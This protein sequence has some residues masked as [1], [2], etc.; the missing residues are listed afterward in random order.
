MVT[1]KYSAIS[2][3]GQKVKGIVEAYNQVDAV[4]RIKNDCDVV[5]NIS[6]VKENNSILTKDLDENKLNAKAFTVMCSQFSIILNAGVSVGRTCHLIAEKTTDKKLKKMLQS[7]AED[8]EAGRSISSAFEER[9]EKFLPP[10]F[11]ETI[12]AGEESGNLDKA[13]DSMYR[14][15]DKQTRMAAKVKSALSYPLFV[16]VIAVVVVVVLMVKVV[17]TFTAIFDSYGADLPLVT[18]MLIAISNFF[19]NSWIFMLLF[20]I[21]IFL[22]FKFYGNTEEGKLKLAEI[23]LKLPILGNIAQ[24]NGASEFANTMAAMLAAGLPLT[25]TLSITARVLSNYYMSTEVGKLSG[26]LEEGHSLGE[27]IRDTKCLPDILI[28]MVSVGEET[29]EME[30][31]LTTISRFYDAELEAAIDSAMKKLEPTLLMIVAGIGG[32]IVV[33]VYVAMFQ[34]YGVM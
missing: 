21:I 9:G 22:F 4:E 29:G 12:R 30:A 24:L 31:T 7:V 14:H 13:F 26:K 19:A 15:F 20:G 11:I 6:E 16:L 27:S 17:P 23:Q 18:K 1:Y 34:M 5:L 32:F 2:K 10:T 8:V 28:D 33:A 3:K 25:R